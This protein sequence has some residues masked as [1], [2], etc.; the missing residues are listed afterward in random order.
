ME[1][2]PDSFKSHLLQCGYSRKT[3]FIYSFI[4]GKLGKRLNY[5]TC[6]YTDV[7]K[8]ISAAQFSLHYRQTIVAALKKYFQYQI[9][10]GFRPDNPCSRLRIRGN[11]NKQPIETD[12]LT[13]EELKKLQARPQRYI[14]LEF[15]DRLLLSFLT[16]QGISAEEACDI[17]LTHV[18]NE[19]GFIKINRSR[20]LAG[21]KL[22][23]IPQQVFLLN[24]YLRISR[25]VLERK[26]NDKLLLGKRG[27]PLTSDCINYIVSTL[28]SLIPDKKL[29]PQLIR[30]SVIV[31]WI[32][33]LK[34]PV[35]Q[36]QLMCGHKWLSST[37]RYK[38]FRAEDEVRLVNRWL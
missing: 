18:L 17:K 32:N 37:E 4:V 25:P 16:V 38:F 30:Q 21:R 24:E 11:F 29:T 35:E 15:R 8:E 34:I 2:Q 1:Y 13:Q 28:K 23:L 33:I 5:L 12:F 22:A 14:A 31:G 20:R 6:T 10:S 3:A 36:V 26:R 27:E 19:P 7:L 9:D